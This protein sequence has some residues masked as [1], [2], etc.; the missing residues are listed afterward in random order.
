MGTGGATGVGG[1]VTSTGGASGAGGAAGAGGPDAAASDGP[2]DASAALVRDQY[3][4]SDG[5]FVGL[6]PDQHVGQSFNVG[7]TGHLMGI[8]IPIFRFGTAVPGDHITLTLY[9]CS[10]IDVCTSTSISTAMITTDSLS[11][12]FPSMT[13]AMSNPGYFDLSASNVPISNGQRYRFRLDPPAAQDFGVLD[14]SSGDAYPA[15]VAFTQIS[16]T[17]TS[18]VLD[19]SIDLAFATYVSD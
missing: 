9:A 17:G 11:T 6:Q 14:S 10:A 3:N 19:R 4:P 5:G 18:S 7:R 15:G 13:P 16:A 8:A 12:T 1:A 2:S